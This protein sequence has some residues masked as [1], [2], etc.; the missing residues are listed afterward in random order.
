MSGVFVVFV[1]CVAFAMIPASA[2][3][4]VTSEK[5]MNLWH[6]QV[7]SGMSRRAYVVTNL[8]F[9]MAKSYLVSVG[10]IFLIKMFPVGLD[11]ADV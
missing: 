9:D 11:H 2:V 3:H 4:M 7:I 1:V 10:T 8:S 5:E 6:M